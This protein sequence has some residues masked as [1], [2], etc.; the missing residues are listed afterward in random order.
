MVELRPFIEKHP[1][2]SPYVAFENTPIYFNDPNGANAGYTINNGTIAFYTK[3]AII[4]DGAT[5]AQAIEIQNT[6]NQKFK[7]G[8]YTAED[9]T[10]YKVKFNIQVITENDGKLENGVINL[11]K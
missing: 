3:I 1:N 6:I 9:G 8:S 2:F 4:G 10:I 11:V 5:K 7:G